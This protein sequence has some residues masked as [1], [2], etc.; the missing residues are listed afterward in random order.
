M[1]VPVQMAELQGLRVALQLRAV[2]QPVWMVAEWAAQ[3]WQALSGQLQQDLGTG[4]P[5]S[6]EL[7]VVDGQ[8]V[9][10]MPRH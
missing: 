8:N 6:P 3:A 9:P 7:A 5:R 10:T 4:L 2:A 1:H